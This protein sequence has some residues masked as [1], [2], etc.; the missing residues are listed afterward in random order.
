MHRFRFAIAA[1]AL[2]LAGGVGAAAGAKNPE[3]APTETV[4]ATVNADLDGDRLFDDLEGRLATLAPDE[5]LSVIVRFGLPVSD[6]GLAQLKAQLGGFAP[7]HRFTYLNGFAAELTA[8]QV[9]LLTLVPGVFAVEENLPVHALNDTA[10]SSFGVAQAR[11]DA[12]VDGDGDGNVAAYSKAD[13]VAAVIDTGIDAAHQDLDEGKVIAFANC[14]GG[15]RLTAP[16]DDHGHGT[17]VA[18]TIAGDGDARPDLLYRGVAPA[19]ALV[20]VKVLDAAGSGTSADVA[21][22][23]EW[24]I[25][26][27]DV[28]GIEAINLSLGSSGCSNGTDAESTSVNRASAAG[29]VVVVAAGNAGPGTCTVGSPGAAADALTV[30]AMADMGVDGFKQAYFSSR[31]PTADGRIKPDVSAPGVS[32]TSAAAGTSNGYA[33]FSGTSMATPF[34]VGTALLMRDANPALTPQQVKDMI[35]S[36]AVDWGRGGDNKT[37]GSRGADNDYGAGRLDGYAAVEQAKGVEIG[38]GPAVPEHQLREGSLAATGA[39]VDYPLNVTDTRFPIAATLILPSVSA[40]TA[41]SPD[42][43]LYLFDPLTAQVATALTARRQDEIGFKPT[44]TGTY[45]LRVKSYSGTGNYFVDISAG[46]TAPP[47]DRS[48]PSVTAVS[49]AEGATGVSAAANVTV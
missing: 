22:G 3:P 49:P 30:G 9:R 13:L 33:V 19:A 17:H 26:N 39:F 8:S 10:Q 5:R 2:G 7:T 20:G 35:R 34:T 24:V 44:V 41:S 15:C 31:G 21:A 23:I 37:A 43:D 16:I 36:T 40:A 12:G 42:F 32:I 6:L 25:A 18:A 14:V 38:T 1:L 4:A 28:Y 45:V 29:I 11:S 47:P 27:K 48:A 46:T